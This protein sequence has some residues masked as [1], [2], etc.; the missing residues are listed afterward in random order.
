MR[1]REAHIACAQEHG[2]NTGGKLMMEGYVIVVASA[3]LIGNFGT[4]IAVDTE[5]VWGRSGKHGAAIGVEDVV[6]HST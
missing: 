3:N 2:K 6:P 1:Q 4:L 5:H